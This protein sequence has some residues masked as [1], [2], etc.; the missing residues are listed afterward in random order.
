MK[1]IRTDIYQNES[2]SAY[3]KCNFL[4]AMIPRRE[5]LLAY[6]KIIDFG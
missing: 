4:S 5:I 3:V 6:P 2:L 1:A